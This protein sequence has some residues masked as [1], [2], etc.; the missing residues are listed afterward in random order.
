MTV[1]GAEASGMIPELLAQIGAK[2]GCTFRWSAVPRMRLESMFEA[3]SADLLLPATQVA[4]RDLQGVFL[5]GSKPAHPDLHHQRTHAGREHRR[6]LERRE[7]RMAL[8][9]GYDYGPE[10][11]A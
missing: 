9:R 2:A 11:R 5:P 4:R 7:L 6:V 3:G 8:V 1:Q 10:Y